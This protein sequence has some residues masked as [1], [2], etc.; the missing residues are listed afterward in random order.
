M[1]H[2]QLLQIMGELGIPDAFVAAVHRFLID[3]KVEVMGHMVPVERGAFQGGP[4]SPLLCALFLWD[5]IKYME[6]PSHSAFHGVPLPWDPKVLQ[7]II[8]II[9]FADDVALPAEDIPQLQ[10]GLNILVAWAVRRK[11]SFAPPKSRALRLVRAPGDYTPTSALPP[12]F[13]GPEVINWVSHHDYLGHL[14]R[15]APPKGKHGTMVVP[16]DE[17][18]VEK[19]LNQIARR[20][21]NTALHQRLHPPSLRMVIQQCVLALALYPTV[22][23]DIDYKRLDSL[24]YNCLMRLFQLPAQTSKTFLQAE[25]GLW[26]S[27]YYAHR[28]AL[29]FAWRLR[30]KYWTSKALEDWID[31]TAG[32]RMAPPLTKKWVSHGVLQRLTKILH[33][34]GLSWRHIDSC[35]RET[36]WEKQVTEAI[37]EDITRLLAAKSQH[38]HLP[39]LDPYGW[40]GETLKMPA[41]S[42]TQKIPLHLQTMG[43]LPRAALRAR[44]FRLRYVLDEGNVTRGQCRLCQKG[45]ENITHLVECP[46]LPPDWI[47]RRETLY[48][49]IAEQA[50]HARKRTSTGRAL[51]QKWLATI[52]WPKAHKILVK[53][54]SAFLRSLINMYAALPPPTWE[55]HATR[56]ITVR[57]VRTARLTVHARSRRR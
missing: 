11:L 37:D 26:P 9:L 39:T 13:M 1:D 27:K 15:E 43:D 40:D 31:S 25:L 56:Q 54:V 41:F 10:V 12:L 6:D 44:Y 47:I 8:R 50:G 51:L 48:D 4:I 45:D 23:Y 35:P 22:I 28:R 18:R 53:R 55:P 34:Y 24:I 46:L 32:G 57:R 30:H 21:T 5:L 2:Q 16:F 49:A 36:A 3:F 19:R 29:R 20:F 52:E 17:K 33:S 38:Y 14:I 7:H 42:I